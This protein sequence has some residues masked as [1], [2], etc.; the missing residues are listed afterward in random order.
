MLL[1]TPRDHHPSEAFVCETERLARLVADMERIRHGDLPQVL[2]GGEDAPI[3]DR[4]TLSHRPALCLAGLSTGH[5][6]LAG[7]NRA[8]A[9][10]DVWLM[11]EDRTWAR[12]L[13]RWYR[14]GRPAEQSGP[15]A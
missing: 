3:L 6:R 15:D 4:W 14:L 12:T 13:S 8:I 2:A 1:F 7:V 10:S 11:S 5:P 9:T